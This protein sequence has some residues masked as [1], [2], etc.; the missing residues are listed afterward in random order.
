MLPHN[1]CYIFLLFQ[2]GSPTL[3]Q[4]S[5]L[6]SFVLRWSLFQNIWFIRM[7]SVWHIHQHI[8][9]LSFYRIDKLVQ[10]FYIFIHMLYKFIRM[11]SVLHIR[12][13]C[14]CCCCFVLSECW[15]SYF[16]WSHHLF[17]GKLSMALL[18]FD[19]CVFVSH[20]YSGSV[21][22]PWY[23]SHCFFVLFVLA[24]VCWCGWCCASK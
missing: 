20:F 3:E 10:M 8:S 16:F 18:A 9:K 1:S 7:V 14:C 13:C 17:S 6:K 15:W 11:V 2:R 23:Q 4:C 22:F 21:S 12:C 5:I 24:F 19:L